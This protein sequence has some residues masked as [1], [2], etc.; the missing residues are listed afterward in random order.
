M[1]S[2]MI[3]L[4]AA[5]S[6]PWLSEAG[7]VA[8]KDS[9]NY[10]YSNIGL[11]LTLGLGTRDVSSSQDLERGDAASLSLGYGVSQHVTLWL[12][13]NK[14]EHGHETEPD[15]K[16]DIVGIDLGVQY[17]LRPN[18]RLRPYGTFGIGTVFLGSE[19]EKVLNGGGV[20]WA[21]GAEYYLVRFLSVGAEFFWKDMQYTKQG[22][23]GVEGDFIKLERP[24]NADTRG[25]LINFT[26]Q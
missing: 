22:E 9:S 14:S 10:K 3:L 17:K 8:G 18:Q 23:N 12:G 21:L 2:K 6:A 7:P 4:V 13:M 20:M 19:G 1:K 26:L 24:I 16:S 25:F 15:R 5:L 11:K